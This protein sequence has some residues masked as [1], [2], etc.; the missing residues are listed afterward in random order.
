MSEKSRA[1]VVPWL[2]NMSKNT[3]NFCPPVTFILLH[4]IGQKLFSILSP[5]ETTITT[6]SGFKETTI[7]TIRFIFKMLKQMFLHTCYIPCI[8]FYP[9][10]FV[11]VL[12]K[13]ELISGFPSILFMTSLKIERVHK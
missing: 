8:F 9:C 1:K 6:I 11:N 5:K 4:G 2:T 12:S 7:T 13:T 10:F 3:K